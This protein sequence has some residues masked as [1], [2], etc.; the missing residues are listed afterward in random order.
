ME[1]MSGHTRRSVVAGGAAAALLAG[2]ASAPA[3]RDIVPGEGL[4][5]RVGGEDAIRRFEGR[6]P[7]TFPGT[8]PGGTYA[9]AEDRPFRIASISKLAVAEAA[10]E[11]DRRGIVSLDADV[12]EWMGGSFRHPAHPDASVTLRRLLAHLSGIIDPAE[13]WVAAPGD[14]RSILGPGIW[15][16][17]ARP[18]VFFRY[19]NLNYGIAATVMEAASG[20][21]FDRL[22]HD[23]LAPLPA[24]GFNWAGLWDPGPGRAGA[25]AGAALWRGGPGAWE[26]QIDDAAARAR[27]ELRAE[28]AILVEEGVDRGDYLAGYVPGTNGTLFSPQGGL[29][30]SF[31]DMIAMGEAW[32]LEPEPEVLWDA[33]TDPDDTGG[34]T[35]DG[36]FVQFG[37]GRYIYP[38]DRSPIPGVAL[39]G[40]VG[41]AYGFYGGLWVAPALD[42]VW[43]FGVLGSAPEGVPMTGGAP[44]LRATNAAFMAEVARAL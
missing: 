28:P 37:L 10:R 1:G 39:V 27:V 20:M 3:S 18:G 29:R 40:H 21:R 36:H 9:F 32:L 15:A 19:S 41:E 12:S 33:A 44:N 13:Y 11:M 42:A 23:M 43:A 34:D 5:L 8:T 16:A 22:V 2:C 7:A 14:I 17:D 38:A 26:A 31:A 6:E 4:W 24:T 25:A 35:A 30:A